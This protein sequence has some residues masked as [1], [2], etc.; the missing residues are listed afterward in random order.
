M[1]ISGLRIRIQVFLDGLIRILLFL[2]SRIRIWIISTRSAQALIIY[3][4]NISIILTFIPKEKE[5]LG[6]NYGGSDRI[7]L[8]GQT[9]VGTD[10]FLMLGSRSGSNP[11]GSASVDYMIFYLKFWKF[12]LLAPS[13]ANMA[14]LRMRRGISSETATICSPVSLETRT[15]CIKGAKWLTS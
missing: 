7:F 14:V 9:T 12:L 2:E 11:P 13:T 3:R 4:D 10:F 1:I 6:W 15:N 8:D 5:I